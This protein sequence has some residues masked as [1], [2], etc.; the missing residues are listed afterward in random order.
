MTDIALPTLRVQGAVS[1]ALA[2]EL[3]ATIGT[4]ELARFLGERRWFAGKGRAVTSAVMRDIVPLAWASDRAAA[5]RLEVEL[6]D[7]A[8]SHYQLLLAARAENDIPTPSSPL[9]L[10]ESEDEG[11]G[12]LFDAIDDPRFRAL[13]GSTVEQGAVFAARGARWSVEPIAG[14]SDGITPDGETRVLA[15]EQSNTSIVYGDRAILKLFRRLEPG[16]HPDVEVGRFLTTRTTF[17]GTP[18]LLAVITF[19]WGGAPS[20]A[21]MVQRFVPGARDAWDYACA[22][23]RDY[24]RATSETPKNPFRGDAERLGRV[25]RALHEALASDRESAAFAPE[26][27][28]AEE[29]EQW[30]AE[31]RGM[32]AQALE[33]LASRVQTGGLD[34]RA[35][36]AARALLG[37]R[38]ALDDRVTEMVSAIGTDVGM[39][40]RV[41]GDYHLGQVLRAPDGRFLIIDFEGEPVRG[42]AERRLKRSPLRDVAG[43]LRSFAYAASMSAREVAGSGVNATVEIRSA[44]W[45]RDARAAFLD[46]Y[47]AADAGDGAS[48]GAAA[49]LPRTRDDVGALLALFEAEKL[50]YELAYELSNRPEWVWVPLRGVAKLL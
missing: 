44:H 38:D 13:L 39:R 12:V 22:A 34:V 36:A 41:H 5:V 17:R 25:T 29:V 3:L 45:E 15:G 16:E 14:Q 10:V 26:R 6:D 48:P 9:A 8:I 24:L 46:G 47:L 28:G 19:E 30:A 32:M 50:F 21:G 23:A 37:R 35:T 18:P 1:S 33:F 7:G 43:M 49:L 40:I 42:M 2:P 11:R 27:A 31:T 4:P 20:V